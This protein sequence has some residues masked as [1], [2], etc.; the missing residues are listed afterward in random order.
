MALR[1]QSVLQDLAEQ[2]APVE[3]LT[4]AEIESLVYACARCDNPYSDVNAELCG[5]PVKVCKGIYLWPLTAGASIWLSEYAE[6]WWRKDSWAYRWAVVYALRN[7]RDSEAFVNLTKERDAKRAILLC[8]LRL[9]CHRKELSVAINRCFGTHEHDADN[10][11][12]QKLPDNEQ[13]EKFAHMVAMLEV[14]SGIPAD[15]W[16]WGKSFKLTLQTYCKMLD[17][18]NAMSGGRGA[19]RMTFELNDALENLANVKMRILERIAKA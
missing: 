1:L 9:A 18:A 16:L 5:R 4:A 13:A 2:G 10:P 14:H 11:H 6:K 3:K 7:A 17:I 12:K 15:K 19:E 8:A